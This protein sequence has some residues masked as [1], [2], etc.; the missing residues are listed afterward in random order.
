MANRLS[1]ISTRG[2]IHPVPPPKKR[3]FPFRHTSLDGTE[4]K[5]HSSSPSKDILHTARVRVASVAATNTLL[6]CALLSFL[7]IGSLSFAFLGAADAFSFKDLL[8]EMAQ[9]E[10]GILLI[11]NYVDI[12]IDEPSIG[13]RWSLLACGEAYVLAG[14]EGSHGSAK[15]GVP[16]MPLNVFVEGTDEPALKYD[17][18]EIPFLTSTGAR[19]N[20]QYLAQFNTDHDLDVHEQP[21]YPFDRYAFV[22]NFYALSP[23]KNESTPLR[24]LKTIDMTSSFDVFVTDAESYVLLADGALIPSRELSLRVRRPTEARIF[25]V[26]LWI[27]GWTLTHISL[28]QLILH[29]NGNDDDE[30]ALAS[31]RL[32]TVTAILF[33]MPQVR[34]AMPDAPD[35]DGV[36][37]GKSSFSCSPT[38]AL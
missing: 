25:V 5:N 23:A 10:P 19:Q 13:I 34:N 7:F 35:L 6:L 27:I 29:L 37:I 15:C 2:L 4:S 30:V 36:L 33:V 24:T 18:G 14:S 20:I 8:A 9:S 3:G 1:Y 38:N 17:P 12:D 26:L 31:R 11:G 28:G 16:N 21:L 32:L 22:S